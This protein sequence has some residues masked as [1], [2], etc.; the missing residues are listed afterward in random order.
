MMISSGSLFPVDAK[1]EEIEQLGR[2]EFVGCLSMDI[3]ES[4]IHLARSHVSTVVSDDFYQRPRA[5]KLHPY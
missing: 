1:K 4:L 2:T 5:F 3:T